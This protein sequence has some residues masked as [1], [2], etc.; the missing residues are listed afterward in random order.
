MWTRP[1]IALICGLLWASAPSVVFAQSGDAV[2]VLPHG[3]VDAAWLLDLEQ[4]APDTWRSTF[5]GQERLLPPA[6][7]PTTITDIKPLPDGALLLTDVG[8]RGVV[9]VD[10][11]RQSWRVLYPAP[12]TALF[13]LS[14]ACAVSYDAAG[15]PRLILIGD[16]TTSSGILYDVAEQRP[17]WAQTAFLPTGRGFIAQVVSQPNDQ[18]WMG[19]WWRSIGIT[20]ADRFVRDATGQR[21]AS[22]LRVANRAHEGAPVATT[23]LEALDE[24]RDAQG[25]PDGGVLLTGRGALIRLDAN[26]ALR[27]MIDAL[28]HP[29]I[30]GQLASARL[31]P[32]GRLAV[33]AFESGQWTQPSTAHR[34]HWLSEPTADQPARLLASSPALTAAPRRVE[35]RVGG[36]TGTLGWAGPP[37]EDQ[38]DELDALTLEPVLT[39]SPEAVRAPGWLTLSAGLANPTGDAI[40]ID[41]ATIRAARATRCD[42]LLGLP[43]RA[44]AERRDQTIRPGQTLDLGSMFRVDDGFAPGSWCVFVEIARGSATR[45]FDQTAPLRVLPAS[46]AVVVTPLDFMRQD[47][48]MG[49]ADMGMEPVPPPA[50]DG[51]DEG[52]GCAQPARPARPSGLV[53]GICAAAALVWA[54]QRRR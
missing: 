45:R 49:G 1:F 10:R 46:D 20:G 53:W 38:A 3:G 37:P 16:T 44:L 32:S 24:V 25:M 26:G 17:V 48:D 21:T 4:P 18:F 19:L 52:C 30:T 12:D 14:A 11:D 43:S 34:V 28:D 31:L 2:Y 13:P 51:E 5:I 40:R 42:E 6:E 7:P 54:R 41:R 35:A 15:L 36:G 39:S 8:G 33:A 22:L 47:D 29:A 27:W 9:W 50:R 23:I